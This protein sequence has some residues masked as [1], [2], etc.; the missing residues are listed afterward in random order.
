MKNHEVINPKLDV[1]YNNNISAGS[2]LAE[3]A[4]PYMGTR[5]YFGILETISKKNIPEQIEATTVM[6]LSLPNAISNIRNETVDPTIFPAMH[7]AMGELIDGAYGTTFTRSSIVNTCVR[8]AKN[9]GLVTNGDEIKALEEQL[10]ADLMGVWSEHS[11]ENL[12]LASG[13][14][15]ERANRG[16]DLMGTD[17]WV[18]LPDN[19]G[20]VSLDIKAQ[21]TTVHRHAANKSKEIEEDYTIASNEPGTHDFAL[22]IAANSEHK[23]AFLAFSNPP[24]EGLAP[25]DFRGKQNSIEAAKQVSDILQYYA[26]NGLVRVYDRI[27]GNNSATY[28]PQKVRV[29]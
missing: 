18:E 8:F 15:V 10:L 17:L 5:G 11:W 20:W 21:P 28:V 23:S 7:S 6:L 24:S 3:S 2:K 9:N 22:Y 27:E 13:L 1:A 25:L 29:K 14:S 16:D 26:E 19:S 12:L 4:L